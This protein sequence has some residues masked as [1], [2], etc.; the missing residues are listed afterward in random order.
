MRVAMIWLGGFL[1]VLAAAWL[2]QPAA[3]RDETKDWMSEA[4]ARYVCESGV[5]TLAAD[6]LKV[7]VGQYSMRRDV[8]Y[9]FFYWNR[10]ELEMPDKAGAMVGKAAVCKINLKTRQVV[11]V[12]FQ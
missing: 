5:R 12:D 4:D 8:E 3:A 6:P 11:Y 1:A 7:K 2:L 9:A 10:S